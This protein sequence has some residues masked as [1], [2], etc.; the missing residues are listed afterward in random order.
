[1][2]RKPKHKGVSTCRSRLRNLIGLGLYNLT[3]WFKHDRSNLY[4]DLRV[5]GYKILYFHFYKI[6][7]A[8]FC[9]QIPVGPKDNINSFCLTQFNTYPSR[10]DCANILDLVFS[11]SPNRISNISVSSESFHT[12]HVL[13]E[14]TVFTKIDRLKPSA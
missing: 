8:E 9:R 1:M 10:K 2:Q 3:S 7:L 6:F 14:F 13:L 5:Y 12:D 11:S 4:H